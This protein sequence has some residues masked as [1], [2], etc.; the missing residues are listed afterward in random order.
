LI[1]QCHPT[2]SCGEQSLY[3]GKNQGPAWMIDQSLTPDPELKNR[4]Q[5]RAAVTL[6]VPIGRC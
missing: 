4:P 3:R 1:R 5:A 6:G 2:P